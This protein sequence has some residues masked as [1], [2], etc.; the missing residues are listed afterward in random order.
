[1]LQS[2]CAFRGNQRW[3][4]RGFRTDVNKIN[5]CTVGYNLNVKNALVKSVYYINMHTTESC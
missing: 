3:E 5:E 2:T 1:M 4:R